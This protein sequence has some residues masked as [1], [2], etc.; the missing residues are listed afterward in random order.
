MSKRSRSNTFLF[1]RFVRQFDHGQESFSFTSCPSDLHQI[2]Y[3]TAKFVS[4]SLFVLVSVPLGVLVGLC[5]GVRVVL[6]FRSPCVFVCRQLD[7]APRSPS[8]T[9][10]WFGRVSRV[11]NVFWFGQSSFPCRESDSLFTVVFFFCVPCRVSPRLTTLS[12]AAQQ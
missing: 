7:R 1:G 9:R 5:P 6:S 12:S 8:G 4:A 3:F 2:S 10:A 11:G